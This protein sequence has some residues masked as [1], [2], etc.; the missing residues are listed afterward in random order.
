MVESISSRRTKLEIKLEL[1]NSQVLQ[2][3]EIQ[4]KDNQT[5]KGVRLNS[6][7]HQTI[8]KSRDHFKRVVIQYQTNA[9]EIQVKRLLKILIQSTNNV[10]DESFSIYPVIIIVMITT[11]KS[12][13]WR[14]NSKIYTDRL[15]TSTGTCFLITTG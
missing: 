4:F 5:S 12:L 11:M 13:C 14:R 15:N 3:Y 1:K 7:N 6:Q 10:T 9:T 8:F 2:I